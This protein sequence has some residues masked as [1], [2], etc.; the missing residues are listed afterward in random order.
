[1]SAFTVLVMAK[2]PVPG[3][4]KTRL[5]AVVGHDLAADLAAAALIDT[6]FACRRSGART[7]VA[8][9]GEL[10]DSPHGAAL[11]RATADCEIFAQEGD[12]FAERLV[13]AHRV[14]GPGVVVQIGMD[15]PQM[16]SDDLV[17]V[18]ARLTEGDDAVLAPATDGGWWALA[19][20][21][22][23]VAVPLSEVEM[24][25]PTTCDDTK[26]ALEAA[27]FRVATGHELCDVDTVEDAQEVA[28]GA[29]GTH[30]ARL[31][32]AQAS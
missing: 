14:A 8:L 20:R 30:F 17:A 31:W 10:A 12:D 9:A 23:A 6:L 5:G 16:T 27:G 15:T 18:A 21:D 24:S 13:H 25:T 26:A 1:M 28:D 19:R 22:P 11:T 4:A 7:V 2:A 32:L 29:P 3:R